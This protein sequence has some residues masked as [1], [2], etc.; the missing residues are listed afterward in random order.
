MGVGERRGRMAHRAIVGDRN[1]RWVYLGI[2]SGRSY[3]IVARRTVVN[4]TSMIEYCRRKCAA[5]HVTDSAILGCYNVVDLGFLAGRI[6]TVVAGITAHS[7]HGGIAVVD[8]RVG[9]ISRV[10]TQRAVDR[11]CRVWRRGCLP[12]GSKGDK[13][14]ASIVARCAVPG[15]AGMVESRGRKSGNRM[16]DVTILDGR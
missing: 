6:G 8:K 14:S 3:A 10:M 12:S 13:G 15:N 2:G 11:S 1:V 5:W 4:D 16:A 9:K 7:Q